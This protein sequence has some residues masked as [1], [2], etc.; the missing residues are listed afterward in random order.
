MLLIQAIFKFLKEQKLSKDR[1]QGHLT[2]NHSPRKNNHHT[3]VLY[4]FYIK[5]I[6]N[7]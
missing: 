3:S 1:P 4:I 6:L 7:N 2:L 5:Y